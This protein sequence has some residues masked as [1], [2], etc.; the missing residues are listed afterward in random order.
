MNLNKT[1]NFQVVLFTN[2]SET[3]LKLSS[4]D[5][6]EFNVINHGDCWVNN[7]LFKYGTRDELIDLIFVDFQLPKYGHPSTDLLNFIMTSVH[8]DH[9]LK[10]FDF[11][12]KYYYDNLVEHLS[13][14][15]YEERVPTLKELHTQL[16]K[17]NI[18]AITA[19][20]MVLPIVLLDPNE[21]IFDSRSSTSQLYNNVRYKTNIE[22]ILPWLDNRGLLEFLT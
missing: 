18:W 11:F 5:P 16:F 15:G 9:K 19:S 8:I 20:V 12:I 22:Q 21:E 1:F 10:D 7:F 17:Y 6:D 4:Y 3:F 13:L 2:M 14:L